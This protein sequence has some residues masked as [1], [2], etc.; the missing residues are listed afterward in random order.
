MNTEKLQ[1]ALF[2]LRCPICDCILPMG[3]ADFCKRCKLQIT[4]IR[5]KV[6]NVCGRP[7]LDE[8]DLC[9][10]CRRIK[11]VFIAGRIVFKYSEV[12]GSI[13]R[14]KYQK[15]PG[16]AL[17]YGPSMKMA[18]GQWLKT[19]EPDALVPVPLNKKRL[20]TRG[21][22]Q[23]QQLAK[24]LSRQT[25]IPVLDKLTIRV[26]NTVPQKEMDRK[27]RV[28]N[29]KNAFIVSEN[30]VKLKTIV[31]VDDIFTTGSTLDSLAYELI[32]TGIENVYFVALSAAGS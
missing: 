22:N 12:S 15:R 25:N 24:E 2:P 29:V 18:L 27:S 8:E 23:S 20:I 5:G 17:C 10:E 13:Y 14:F 31:L 3:T 26:R 16:Y 1:R 4:L 32:K 28:S 7:I 6:C 21:Y 9:E 11:H 30:V 19:I